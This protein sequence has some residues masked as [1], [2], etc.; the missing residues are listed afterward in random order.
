MNK[1]LAISRIFVFKQQK[2]DSGSLSG[3]LKSRITPKTKMRGFVYFCYSIS[4]PPSFASLHFVMVMPS[5]VNIFKSFVYQCYSSLKACGSIVGY[6]IDI[7]R[8][9]LFM[10]GPHYLP[11]HKQ[12][13]YSQEKTGK[14]EVEIPSYNK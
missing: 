11:S 8:A 14:R 7:L 5:K 1:V 10:Q 3:F 6:S 13:T 2:G 9:V 12:I 4:T